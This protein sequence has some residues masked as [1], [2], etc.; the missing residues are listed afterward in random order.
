M[1]TEESKKKL[2]RNGGQRKSV[3]KNNPQGRLPFDELHVGYE[4]RTCLTDEVGETAI[5]PAK[6]GMF[7]PLI[8]KGGRLI[9]VYP[10][11]GIEW[12]EQ[13]DPKTECPVIQVVRH[14]QTRMSQ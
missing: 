3:K 12:V 5:C 1:L 11:D 10:K 6:N 2:I 13:V 14:V 8:I 4:N 9:A 7:K